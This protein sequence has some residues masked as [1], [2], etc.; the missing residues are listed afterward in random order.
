MWTLWLV[1]FANVIGQGGAPQVVTPLATYLTQPECFQ[2]INAIALGLKKV[3]SE[4][5]PPS[6]GLMMCVPG[7]LVRK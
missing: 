4:N 6:P 3:Y 2:A 1:T 5:S 7:T